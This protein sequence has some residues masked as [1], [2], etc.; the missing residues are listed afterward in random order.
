MATLR[1][2]SLASAVLIRGDGFEPRIVEVPPGVPVTWRN[3][4]AH[5]HT[6][7]SAEIESGDILPGDSFTYAFDRPGHYRYFC[8]IHPRNVGEVFVR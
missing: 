8:M 5:P 1:E 3:E 7:S 2:S 4:D 6:I